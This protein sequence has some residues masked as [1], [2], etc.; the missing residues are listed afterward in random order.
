VSFR[1]EINDVLGLAQEAGLVDKHFAGLH[2]IA[3]ARGLVL[4]KIPRER[5]LELQGN[6]A[7]HDPDTI[8]CV[9]QRIALRGQYVPLLDLDHRLSSQ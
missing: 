1:R 4:F 7:P 6:S 8:Y 2:L 5:L 3:A 9:D